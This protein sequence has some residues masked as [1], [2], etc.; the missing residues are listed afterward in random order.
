MTLLT[1]EQVV[2]AFGDPVPHL[3]PDGTIKA[4]W[5]AQILGT[6]KLPA[7]LKLSW[8]D[9]RVTTFRAHKR[10]V[11]AFTAAFAALFA[12]PEAWAS[13]GDFG[14]CYNFRTVRGKNA[15]SRHSWG[16]AI[17]MDVLDNPMFGVVPRVHPRVRAIMREHGFAWGGATIWGGD[18]PW[19]RRDAMHF[20]PSAE[21]VSK[22]GA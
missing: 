21:S 12:D 22:L 10:L 4:S 8:G 2:R 3:K 16:I 15:L 14:G 6:V 18:F 9:A 1:Q 11:P 5:A 13:I 19:A 7:P 20:E 17:D